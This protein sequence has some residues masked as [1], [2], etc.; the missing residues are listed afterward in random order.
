M[1]KLIYGYL[2][3]QPPFMKQS[4]AA[5]IY[6]SFL[7]LKLRLMVKFIHARGKKSC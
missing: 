2:Y 1:A 5:V 6:M 4:V 7:V 3:R